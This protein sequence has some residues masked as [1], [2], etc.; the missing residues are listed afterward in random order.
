MKS[1]ND[2][3]D[4]AGLGMEQMRAA[5]GLLFDYMHH[6][7]YS[8]AD[9]ALDPASLPE[10][11]VNVGKGM[12][13]LNSL[14]AEA[15]FFANEISN[16]NLNCKV[17]SAANEIAAPLKSLHATL[18]HL[19]WQAQQV[20]SGDYQQHVDFMGAFSE[21]FNNMTAQLEEQRITNEKEKDR[22]LL[23]IGESTKAR[24]EAEYN[25]DL[26]HIQRSRGAVAG[27]GRKRLRGR[28]D[29][30]NGTDRR[31]RGIGPRAY[32]AKPSRP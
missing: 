4:N 9:A 19:T 6:M 15:R 13:F 1:M 30:R 21:A 22:L 7:I 17:P 14:I 24:Q 23:A 26:M 29:T 28:N 5:A 27:N 11:L 31:I 3:N 25:H 2:P 8:P 12:V 16:G 18:A 10:V 20:A 32:M